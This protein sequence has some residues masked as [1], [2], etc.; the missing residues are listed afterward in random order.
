MWELGSKVHLQLS[1]FKE[2]CPKPLCW[3][4]K[5]TH[6]V[7]WKNHGLIPFWQWVVLRWLHYHSGYSHVP[8]VCLQGILAV[9]KIENWRVINLSTFVL[10]FSHLFVKCICMCTV[11][12]PCHPWWVF[13]F[14]HHTLS[15]I[16][17]YSK[18][19]KPYNW[20]L[21]DQRW[22]CMEQGMCEP[23]WGMLSTL[24]PVSRG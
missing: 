7:I 14:Y 2:C 3:H 18:G 5:W 1:L 6:Q 11:S 21:G 4:W 8:P 22:G 17:R 9:R 16:H 12:I 20:Q 23:K 15:T 24:Q 13:K 19:K 10:H